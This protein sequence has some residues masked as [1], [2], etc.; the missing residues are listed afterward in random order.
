MGHLKE[1][2]F[3]SLG[4][5]WTADVVAEIEIIL[6]YTVQNKVKCTLSKKKS[7]FRDI[8]RN[9]E[10]NEIFRAVYRFPCYISCY[11]PENRLSSGQ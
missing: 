10:K 9:V 5:V 1:H 3:C 6:L 4:H 7:N 11:I 8:T 2:C